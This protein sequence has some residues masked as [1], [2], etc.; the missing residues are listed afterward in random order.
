M[1]LSALP[2]APDYVARRTL[3]WNLL[4]WGIDE[5]TTGGGGYC[6][7]S[8]LVSIR[9]VCGAKID[10]SRSF[11]SR[12][13]LHGIPRSAVPLAK[14]QAI[15][16]I[17]IVCIQPLAGESRS[18]AIDHVIVAWTKEV[19]W[20]VVLRESLPFHVTLWHPVLN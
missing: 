12:A 4:K 18:D 19:H 6:I 2:I 20:W 13:R 10:G 15:L 9:I 17:P 14:I 8:Q 11:H 5:S 7:S 1:P 3:L 16:T